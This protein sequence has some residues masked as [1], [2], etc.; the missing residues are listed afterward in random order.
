MVQLPKT[1]KYYFRQTRLNINTHKETIITFLQADIALL[2]DLMIGLCGVLA[3]LSYAE[4]TGGNDKK[5]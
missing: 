4:H 1:K 5:K 2:M 3:G